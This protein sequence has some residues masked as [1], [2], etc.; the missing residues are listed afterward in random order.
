[1]DGGQPTAPPLRKDPLMG[2]G[3]RCKAEARRKLRGW[4]QARNNSGAKQDT[5]ERHR[6]V[7][8]GAEDAGLHPSIVG[9]Y[10]RELERLR[11]FAEVRTKSYP[12]DINL[13]ML[14]EYRATWEALYPSSATR[15]QVQICLRRFLRFCH[16]ANWL[17]RVPASR[18]F[19]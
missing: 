2:N 10:H 3:R 16:N 19:P 9:K 13:E 4:R 15:Q 17:D 5:T 1:M 8:V 6:P 14:L 12:N 11:K 18:P 7:P